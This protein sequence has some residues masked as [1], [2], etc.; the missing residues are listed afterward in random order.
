[1]IEAPLLASLLHT[2]TSQNP[3]P[4]T[5]LQKLSPSW[6]KEGHAASLIIAPNISLNSPTKIPL[7]TLWLLMLYAAH[8]AIASLARSLELKAPN[9]RRLW[10]ITIPLS[11]RKTQAPPVNVES[12]VQ[13]TAMLHITQ[14]FMGGFQLTLPWVGLAF[15]IRLHSS[16]ILCAMNHSSASAFALLTISAHK[17]DFPSKIKWFLFFHSCHKIYGQLLL[18]SS[19]TPS[20]SLEE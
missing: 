9:E 6:T 17:K 7:F 18:S 19:S 13:S 12:L 15:S 11:S 5:T 10:H 8:N 20:L 4:S 16:S 1:M 3:I 14:S 2:A